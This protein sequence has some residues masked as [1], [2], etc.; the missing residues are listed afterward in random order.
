MTQ[1]GPDQVGTRNCRSWFTKK[2]DPEF[3]EKGW[4]WGWGTT[5]LEAAD[6]RMPE[7]MRSVMIKPLNIWKIPQQQTGDFETVLV[8]KMF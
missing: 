2:K 7:V 5:R 1:C 6:G 8:N 3:W 4:R